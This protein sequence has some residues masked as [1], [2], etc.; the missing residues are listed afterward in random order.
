MCLNRYVGITCVGGV[1]V[2]G[3]SVDKERD[4]GWS[5]RKGSRQRKRLGLV[6]ELVQSCVAIVRSLSW[7]ERYLNVHG[8]GVDRERDCG[9]NAGQGCIDSS[10]IG[11]RDGADAI[12]PT[13]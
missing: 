5:A 13:I 2:H 12:S 9:W 4:C 8:R 3:R 1:N 10:G 6:S 7:V 11:V